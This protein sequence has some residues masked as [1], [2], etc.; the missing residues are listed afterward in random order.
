MVSLYFAC[1]RLAD[2]VP[3]MLAA[4]AGFIG[5][6]GG[7]AERPQL[8]SL[9]L[10]AVWT[11]GWLT[12]H[13]E[14][15]VTWWQVPLMWIWAMTHGLWVIGL[16][17][18][19]VI[20]VGR[21]I[22]HRDVPQLRRDGGLLAGCVAAVC[23]TPNGPA[24]LLAPLDV[25]RT[26]A[27]FV[28]EWQPLSWTDPL[29]LIGLGP[30]LLV[31]ILWSWRREQPMW[32]RAALLAVAFGC[33]LSMGRLVAVGA[34]LA[35]PLLAE[36]LQRLRP[37]PAL[38]TARFE[39]LAAAGLAGAALMVMGLVSSDV[40]S[41]PA[42]SYPVALSPALKRLPPATVVLPDPSMS[43]WLLWNAPQARTVLD[44][45]AEV[46]DRATITEYLELVKG[47]GSLQAYTARHDVTA[48]LLPLA[49]P[50]QAQLSRDV[51]WRLVGRDRGYTLWQRTGQ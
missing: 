39:V 15:Q 43:G 10:L 18:A 34:I 41:S 35:A 24:I 29:L 23:L 50:L 38:R 37:R 17:V 25:S 19:V 20:G 1:R 51:N 16:A 26:A 9:S 44:L 31:L 14:G 32:S 36:T 22:D 6:S 45:R 49:S 8:V 28:Q 42:N 48:A 21:Y 12:P 47:R 33:A 5:C 13:R 4:T 27:A 2:P 30:A 7:L 3:A 46:Y 11:V 40:A